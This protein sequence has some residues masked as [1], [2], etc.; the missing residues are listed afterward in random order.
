M[1]LLYERKRIFSKGILNQ[2]VGFY[3]TLSAFA[4]HH[5]PGGDL[6]MPADHPTL[7]LKGFGQVGNSMN[8]RG[9]RGNMEIGERLITMYLFS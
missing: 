1:Y 9:K 6:Q 3:S 8:M 7:C 5:F 2:K 4:F